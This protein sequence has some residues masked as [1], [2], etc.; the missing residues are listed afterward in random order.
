M[1]NG[2]AMKKRV[3]AFFLTLV[4]AFGLLPVTSFAAESAGEDTVEIYLSISHDADFL[5]MPT[6]EI[7]AFKAMIP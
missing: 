3:F 6:D 7:M 5:E 4:L 1:E 2:D